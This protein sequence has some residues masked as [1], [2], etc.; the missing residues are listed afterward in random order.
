MNDISKTLLFISIIISLF[1]LFT[2][3]EENSD[4]IR[5]KLE[6]RGLPTPAFATNSELKNILKNY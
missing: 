3:R 2:D 6:S 1:I 5:S 4:K